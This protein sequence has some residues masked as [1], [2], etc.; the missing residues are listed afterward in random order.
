MIQAN[1]LKDITGQTFGRLRVIK[2]YP[3][4]TKDRK[5]RWLCYCDPTLQ[6]CGNTCVVSG[7]Q[8]R[9][10]ITQSCGCLQRDILSAR[11]HKHGMFKD[12]S[13]KRIWNI[14]QGMRRRCYDSSRK[15]YP[16]YGGRGIYICDEWYT[17]DNI[18]I[19]VMAFRDW[20][21]ANGYRDDLS[22]DRKD[23]DGPYAPWNCR[24]VTDL[25]QSNNRRYNNHINDGDEI[26]TLSQFKRKYNIT[27]HISSKLA[28]G[29]T[30]DMLV[31]TV[32][33]PDENFHIHHD[34]LYD[35][36]GF[37]RMIPR[38]N[39]YEEGAKVDGKTI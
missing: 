6:G 25:V 32:K 1:N 10:G 18:S 29:W 28:S 37:E 12:Y 7:K 5:A 23:N 33:H 30:K 19:G 24:W 39:Q 3:E 36:D 9:L 11:N 31:Y 38:Y 27:Y 16:N 15:D 4:N 34:R 17:P 20:A 26:L 2:R 21:L 35:S 8:L 14:H 22:I 13:M